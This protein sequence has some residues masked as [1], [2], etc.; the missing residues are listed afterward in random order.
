MLISRKKVCR[1]AS[2]PMPDGRP[3][4]SG[5]EKVKPR[6]RHLVSARPFL[7]PN[8][9]PCFSCLPQ[10]FPAASPARRSAPDAVLEQVDETK[11]D[12]R[13]PVEVSHRLVW[14]VKRHLTADFKDV[15]YDEQE[16]RVPREDA[17]TSRLRHDSVE[18][19]PIRRQV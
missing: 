3:H 10:V 17:R 16:D 2:N 8:G 15:A 7:Y 9:C 5:R 12:S 18:G 14:F 11:I 6:R 4:C 13:Q 1:N 19:E